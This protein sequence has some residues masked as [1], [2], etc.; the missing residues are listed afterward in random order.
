MRRRIPEADCP[1]QLQGVAV[2]FTVLEKLLHLE[3]SAP[4]ATV[5]DSAQRLM[6]QVVQGRGSSLYREYRDVPCNPVAAGMARCY[7]CLRYTRYVVSECLKS[8]IAYYF[9]YK[10]RCKILETR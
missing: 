5:E 2:F 7:C 4:Y 10:A 8:C 3:S 6:L 1:V 9:F